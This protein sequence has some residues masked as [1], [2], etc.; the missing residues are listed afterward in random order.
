[1][2]TRHFTAVEDR[3]TG[4]IPLRRV[5][6]T[7]LA[8]SELGLGTAPLGNLY[9]P[10]SDAT[11]QAVLEAAVSAGI[12]YVDTA[13]FYGFGLSERRVGDGLRGQR[14]RVI[15]TKVGRLLV[16]DASVGDD[17]L[18]FGFRSALP[19]KPVFNYSHDAIL[20]SWEAS[21]QRLG[22]AR[23][24]LLFVHDVGTQ[25]H[26]SAHPGMWQQLTAGG[27][28]R[29][30]ERLRDEGSISG[31]GL[32]VNEIAVCLEAMSFTRIDAL[33]LA[34]RYTLLE[35]G[36]MDEL[37]PRA[38][39][40]GTAVIVGGPYNSGILA[41]GT[42][43]AGTRSKAPPLYNYAPAPADVM[44]RVARIE[45]VCERHAVP[46]AAAALQFPLAHPQVA[47]VIPGIASVAQ[48][49]DTLRFYRASIPPRFWEDLKSEGLLRA[50]AVVP[51]RKSP[52]DLKES[53]R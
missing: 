29:A 36:A 20:R 40:S 51:N 16:P 26:G 35:Q 38:K 41:A 17:S 6:G 10:M 37:L 11:A 33:L 46:L 45:A 32:G 12:H 18:R 23:V 8:L 21:L 49:F 22:L 44:A 53:I 48:L 3:T 1:M 24:D 2:A 43:A 9:D 5:G 27:G 7:G 15:S 4:T 34:G 19:F 42:R 14:S 28:F 25:T 50:D 30:L 52:T 31:F 39:A 13:P 47:S